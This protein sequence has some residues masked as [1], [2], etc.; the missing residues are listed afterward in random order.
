MKKRA[1]FASQVRLHAVLC[2]AAIFLSACGGTADTMGDNRALAADTTAV[3]VQ[4]G[5][6]N[7]PVNAVPAFDTAVASA[8]APVAAAVTSTETFAPT[9]PAASEQPAN[10]SAAGAADMTATAAAA[11]ATPA[12]NFDLSGYQST[13][14]ASDAARA[15]Q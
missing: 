11:P 5:A 9:E 15:P 3:P 14:A 10:A 4:A 13:D 12:A 2:G 7:A 1:T 6:G 8:A